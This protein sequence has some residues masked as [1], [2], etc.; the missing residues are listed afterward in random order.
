M[1][2]PETNISYLKLESEAGFEIKIGKFTMQTEYTRFGIPG[3]KSQWCRRILF[4][5]SFL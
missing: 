1:I 3:G 2:H 5:G 4:L